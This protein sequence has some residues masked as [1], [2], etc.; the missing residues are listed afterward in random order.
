MQNAIATVETVEQDTSIRRRAL[1][2]VPVRR[3]A[4]E[5]KALLEHEKLLRHMA[6]PFV[7]AG[8]S[9][10][11]LMQEARMAF[12][13]AYRSWR[14]EAALWTYA[15][16]FVL[17]ALFRAVGACLVRASG[18]D[19]YFDD[20]DSGGR[21][22]FDREVPDT[23]VPQDLRVIAAELLALLTEEERHI[24]IAHFGE[25]RTLEELGEELGRRHSSIQ[26]IRDNALE[27]MRAEV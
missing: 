3:D 21:F 7:R 11:D 17:G 20:H 9:V 8:V 19:D 24:V 22:A 12:V 26:T 15:R 25:G 23:S 2:V 16:R 4:E 27:K 5:S 14:R 13:L 6:Q 18:G 1:R 10:D